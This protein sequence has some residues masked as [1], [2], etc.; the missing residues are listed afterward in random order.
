MAPA[1]TNQDEPAFAQKYSAQP[2]SIASI[3]PAMI[4]LDTSAFG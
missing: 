2:K 3:A 1:T 4:L